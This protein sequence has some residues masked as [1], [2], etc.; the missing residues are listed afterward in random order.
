MSE[1]VLI[2]PAAEADID[3]VI[4]AIVDSQRSGTAR[5]TFCRMY[6]VNEEELRRA[7]GEIL[8]ME[9]PGHELSLSGFLVCE[10][11]GDRAGV[12]GSWVEGEGEMPSSLLKSNVLLQ[13]LGRQTMVRAAER[14]GRVRD[15]SF[16]REPG[17]MQL[18]YFLVKREYALKGIFFR[19]FAAQ[20]R[21]QRR[22]HPGLT[23]I[24]ALMFKDNDRAFKACMRLGFTI[25]AEKRS[26]SPD[27]L[28]LYPH[29][30]RLL[31]EMDV[32]RVP[33]LL[34]EHRRFID[35]IVWRGDDLA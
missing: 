21:R 9:V 25:A 1:Q 4:E 23:K 5:I 2:R 3:F 16:P 8:R 33:A 31:L 6:G 10:I 17:A 28:E 20:V 32:A 22:R 14:L 13:A 24:Q 34:E 7:L 15:L 27:V 11:N 30:T 18:E 35:T 26:A 12:L 19:L 29:D